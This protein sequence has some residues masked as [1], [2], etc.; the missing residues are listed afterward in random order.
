MDEEK[1]GQMKHHDS[2]LSLKE[3]GTSGAT[4]VIRAKE[5]HVL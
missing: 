4:P 5:S 1:P 3:P 2:G